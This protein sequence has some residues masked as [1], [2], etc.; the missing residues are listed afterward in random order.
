MPSIFT[1]SQIQVL[2]GTQILASD[3]IVIEDCHCSSSVLDS[4]DYRRSRNMLATMDQGTGQSEHSP[5][6][7]PRFSESLTLSE[8]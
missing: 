4:S 3:Q 5:L 2:K 8:S 7:S 1:D 6:E